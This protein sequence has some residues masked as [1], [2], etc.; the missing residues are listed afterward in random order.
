MKDKQGADI[1]NARLPAG[2]MENLITIPPTAKDDVVVQLFTGTCS[3]T[4]SSDT[5]L[6]LIPTKFYELYR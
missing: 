6:L 2:T 3:S 1:T 4:G 5:Q